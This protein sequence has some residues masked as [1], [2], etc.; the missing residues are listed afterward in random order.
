MPSSIE[1]R[2]VFAHVTLYL[3]YHD[4]GENVSL[5]DLVRQACILRL[6][7]FP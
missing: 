3:E 5:H 4:I 7:G 2:R 6:G 1:R